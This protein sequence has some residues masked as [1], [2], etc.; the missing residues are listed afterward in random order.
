MIRYPLK[1]LIPLNRVRKLKINFSI[2]FTM[3]A[4][5]RSQLTYLSHTHYRE[6]DRKIFLTKRI[7]LKWLIK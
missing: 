6:N 5:T 4:K 7:F 2:V 1:N 3:K